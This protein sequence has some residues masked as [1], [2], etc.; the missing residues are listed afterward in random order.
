MKS[1]SKVLLMT[2][3][4]TVLGGVAAAQ[5][6]LLKLLGIRGFLRLKTFVLA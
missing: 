2:V 6:R 5:T 1:I 4:V 3:V